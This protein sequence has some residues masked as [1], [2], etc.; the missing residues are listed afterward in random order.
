MEEIL[1]ETIFLN[2]PNP[3]V[4]KAAPRRSWVKMQH[5][6]GNINTGCK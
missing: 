5:N 6:A 2:H 3:L 4:E 1:S